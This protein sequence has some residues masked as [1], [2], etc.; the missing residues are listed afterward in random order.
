MFGIVDDG[1][2]E[3][4]NGTTVWPLYVSVD[5]YPFGLS[6]TRLSATLLNG[7][8]PF[9]ILLIVITNPNDKSRHPHNI[10][11]SNLSNPQPY[12]SSHQHVEMLLMELHSTCGS[13]SLR[14]SPILIQLIP[15]HQEESF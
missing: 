7:L 10:L 1:K 6:L 2:S 5:T 8:N 12:A 13:N 11:Q 3:A 9:V 15:T 14:Q 4:P